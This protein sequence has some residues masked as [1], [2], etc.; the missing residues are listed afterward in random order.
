MFIC[1]LHPNNNEENFSPVHKI[2]NNVDKNVTIENFIECTQEQ[3]EYVNQSIQINEEE[4]RKLSHR[5]HE[6]SSQL[7]DL[8]LKSERGLTNHSS[9]EKTSKVQNNKNTT[10]QCKIRSEVISFENSSSH[11]F[12]NNS[13]IHIHSHS[14]KLTVRIDYVTVRN[15]DHIALD[16]KK[17][18]ERRT[19]R[20][21][22]KDVTIY[23][24]KANQGIIEQ[25]DMHVT[26]RTSLSYDYLNSVP[27]PNNWTFFEH[28]H[29][30][31]YPAHRT[32]PAMTRLRK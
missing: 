1:K 21:S 4:L 11:R 31:K 13:N 15:L 22:V 14:N 6:L 17:Q 10:Q 26:F 3:I 30:S 7:T 5:I 32:Y 2:L 28:T 16:F 27:F 8:N 24:Y 19:G 18:F 23:K 20:H 9:Q 25:I 12:T 29:W